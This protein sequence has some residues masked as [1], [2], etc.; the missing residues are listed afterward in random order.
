MKTSP[1]LNRFWP[2]QGSYNE[3]A[4]RPEEIVSLRRFSSTLS[5]NGQRESMTDFPNYTDEESS[6]YPDQEGESNAN[7]LVDGG[8]EAWKV[9]LAAW[10]VD[11]MTSGMKNCEKFQYF[12]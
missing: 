8:W 12:H 4:E 3:H 1:G 7:S 6:E 10:I 11:F 5:P 2:F 9:L